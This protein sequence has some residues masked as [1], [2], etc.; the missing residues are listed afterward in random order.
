MT[1][2]MVTVLS[3]VSKAV[4]TRASKHHSTWSVQREVHEC[5]V[6]FSYQQKFAIRDNM[7]LY[8]LTLVPWCIYR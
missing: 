5:S 1:G 7:T 6:S 4:A 8:S 3:C 2:W